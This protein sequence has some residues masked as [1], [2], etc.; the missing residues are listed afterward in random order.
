MHAFIASLT[1][2]ANHIAPLDLLVRLC[3]AFGLGM[4]ISAIYQATRK[5]KEYSSF[6]STLV[7]LTILIAMVTNVIGDN[8]ARAFSL[9][10]ALGIVRFRTVVRDTEDT[11]YV[12]FSVVIG[13]AIGASYL[14][15]AGIGIV[16]IGMA[17]FLLKGRRNKRSSDPTHALTVRLSIELDADTLLKDAFSAYATAWRLQSVSTAKQ[18]QSVDVTYDLSMRSP[19]S[20]KAFVKELNH[21]DG[22]QSVELLRH[23]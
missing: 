1:A 22:I 19:E 20:A 5:D 14:A 12:I 15:V 6:P 7:L 9:V 4:V 16:V 10:G 3:L 13:M 21:L 8:V 18:G 23:N 17:A 2:G 11:A